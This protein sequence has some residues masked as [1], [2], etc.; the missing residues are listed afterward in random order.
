MTILHRA[1]ALAVPLVGRSPRH[2]DE[3][4]YD[5]PDEYDFGHCDD[6]GHRLQS[7]AEQADGVCITCRRDRTG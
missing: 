3:C 4:G 6:C 7:G 2:D 1:P 5:E